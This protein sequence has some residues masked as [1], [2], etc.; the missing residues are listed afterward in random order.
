MENNITKLAKKVSEL[1]SIISGKSIDI[2]IIFK[3][4]KSV[5]PWL[6]R[7]ESRELSGDD[8]NLLLSTMILNFSKEIQDL[9]KSLEKK[10]IIYNEAISS[11]NN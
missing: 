6:V 8:P 5:K 3:S 1:Y 4:D 2:D 9:K 11:T 7:C 10:I